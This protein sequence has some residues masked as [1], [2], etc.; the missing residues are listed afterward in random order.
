MSKA[1]AWR[2]R[3][4]AGAMVV[5]TPASIFCAVVFASLFTGASAHSDVAGDKR[6]AQLINA[7]RL[8]VIPMFFGTDTLGE[9]PPKPN[10]P[11]TAAHSSV[12]SEKRRKELAEYA[13][14][15]R[16]LELH[17]KARLPERAAARTPFEVIPQIEVEQALKEFKMTPPELF[18]NG[19]RLSGGRFD[20]P[21]ENQIRRVSARLHADAVLLGVL[22]EP[23]KDNGHYYFDPIGG[24]GYDTPKVHDK[25]TFDLRLAD[26]SLVLRQTIDV[27]HPLTRIG[28]RVFVVA[29]WIETEDEIIEDLMD[30]VTR[31]TPRR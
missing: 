6:R 4:H 2:R 26:G 18:L 21:D 10:S 5:N 23:R 20:M 12:V 31:Y 3:R 7:K 16:K 13:E 11:Q 22:D 25:A 15:L 1:P 9:L 27:V 28:S 29:D 19:G 17:A 8:L 24:A 30:E 14:T